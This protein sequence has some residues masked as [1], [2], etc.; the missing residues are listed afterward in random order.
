LGVLVTWIRKRKVLIGTIFAHY[1]QQILDYFVASSYASQH[2]TVLNTSGG[3]TRINC[4]ILASLP[5]FPIITLPEDLPKLQVICGGT[6]IDDMFMLA[7]SSSTL[8]ELL[9]DGGTRC[10]FLPTCISLERGTDFVK[11]CS[12]RV[13]NLRV[14]D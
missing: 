3:S 6:M 5:T 11:V 1:V 12:A 10:V 8:L 2:C 14:M 4:G 13:L 7:I 9:F